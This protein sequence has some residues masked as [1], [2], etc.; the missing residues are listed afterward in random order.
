MH[1]LYR[2][3]AAK[4]FADTLSNILMKRNYTKYNRYCYVMCLE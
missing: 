1:F 4:Q 3:G 2:M